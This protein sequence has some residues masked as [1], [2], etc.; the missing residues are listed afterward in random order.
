MTAEQL[1]QIFLDTDYPHTS[2]TPEELKAAEY[3]KACCEAMGVPARLESFRV[4][5]AEMEAC[6]VTA[7]GEEIPCKAFYGCGS[8]EAEGELYYMPALDPVS[9][10]GAKDRI[11]LLDTQGVGFWGYQDLIKAGACG[12]LFQYGNMY[13]PHADIDQRDLREAVVGSER[14]VLCAMIHSASAVELVRR[15]PCRVRIAVRQ[16]EF[17]GESHNVVAEIPGR[18]DEFITLTAHYDSTSLSH[19][20]Y[21]NM[22]GCAGLLGVMEALKDLDLNYGLRFVFC[23]SEE[24]GLLGSKA[25]TAAHEDELKKTVLN[26]NLDMIGSYM[27]KFIAVCSTDEGMVSYVRY[28]AAELGWGVHARQGVYSSDS[29]PFADKGVPAVT[30]ARIAPDRQATIHNRYDTMDLLSDGQMIADGEFIA[31]FTRR[32]ADSSVC[33]AKRPLPEKVRDEL[34]KYLLRK[35]PE[36]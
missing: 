13:Y 28:L 3:L 14:K 24:R 4:A 7:D 33:P 25:Y 36:D 31:E 18:R 27:G 15:G 21:D 8:G 26:V 30:F 32:M 29:T 35:R 5:M 6:S 9:L 20:A 19:G 10:A 22:T 2:G 12:I 34:D 23:G 11:V 16:R 17:D 1:K